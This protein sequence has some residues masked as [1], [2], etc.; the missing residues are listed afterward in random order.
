M[1]RNKKNKKTKNEN[2]KSKTLEPIQL[3]TK[4]AT[5]IYE[6]MH[7]VKV[8]YMSLGKEEKA[9]ASAKE[10][11][12]VCKTIMEKVENIVLGDEV[13]EED[14]ARSGKKKD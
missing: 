7:D 2:K 3:T 9:A 5:L 13:G 6:L 1:S 14:K 11:V 12:S 8:T 10:M 4:E